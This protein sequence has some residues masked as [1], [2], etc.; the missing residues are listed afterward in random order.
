QTMA[1]HTD[2]RGDLWIAGGQKVGRFRNGRVEPIAVPNTIAN[3]RVMALTTDAQQS[4]WLCTALKGV[5]VWD[6]STLSRFEGQTDIAGKACQSIFTDSQGRVWIGLLSAGA[7]M[8]ENG[9]FRTFGARE[10]LA[11]GTILAVAEDRQG[12]IW[13]SATG[14]VSRFQKGRLT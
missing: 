14:G 2:R 4:V 13:L 12:A 8:Y 1:L 6:G 5:M 11:R 10:G 9:M 7:A 3:S